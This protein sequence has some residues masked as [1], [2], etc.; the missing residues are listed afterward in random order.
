MYLTDK[1]KARAKVGEHE[2]PQYNRNVFHVKHHAAAKQGRPMPAICDYEGSHYRTE[3]WTPERQF[4]DLADRYALRALLPPQGDT[5][6]EV[7]AGFGRLAAL[8]AGY[9]RVVLFDYAISLLQEAREHLGDDPRFLFVAG[10]VY[11]LPF[12]SHTFDAAVMVRVMHHLEDVPT[13]LGHLSRI[14]RGQGALILEFANKRHLKAIL[15]YLLRRQTWSPFDLEPYPFVPLNYDFHPRW[16]EDRLHEAGLYIDATRAVSHFRI[17]WLKQHVPPRILARLDALLQRP[18]ALLKISPSVFLRARP[19]DGDSRPSQ[20]L[21]FR[22]PA[23]GHEPLP[24]VPHDIHCAGCS[25]IWPYRDGI[26]SFK[27]V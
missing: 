10:D 20:N 25:R 27:E 17:P 7:G 14:L 4:E 26:Y 16:V 1:E 3:F 21:A 6:I 22:C 13:A 5:L 8:Y 23:C 12:A 15:R 11:R 18:G 9:N 19:V 2:L 24:I